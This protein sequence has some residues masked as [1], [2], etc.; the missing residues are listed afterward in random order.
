MRPAVGKSTD[1]SLVSDRK[2][3]SGQPA[4]VIACS[5][6]T[7]RAF[8]HVSRDGTTRTRVNSDD[9]N[10]VGSDPVVAREAQLCPWARFCRLAKRTFGNRTAPVRA[11]KLIAYYCS[12]IRMHPSGYPHSVLLQ[13]P[14]PGSHAHNIDDDTNSQS[15]V[16]QETASPQ[17]DATWSC[18]RDGTLYFTA[19][20]H[21]LSSAS[22]L[23]YSLALALCPGNLSPGCR[24]TVMFAHLDSLDGLCVGS[25]AP[26]AAH[27]PQGF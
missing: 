21:D 10:V 25:A 15:C 11:S 26:W 14:L 12:C 4:L 2:A 9:A 27:Q 23:A 17:T 5:P 19:S 8:F 1:L 22:I 18:L 13:S 7:G 6:L 3:K 20:N 24:A 16:H